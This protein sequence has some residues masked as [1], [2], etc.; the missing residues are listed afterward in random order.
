MSIEPTS[1]AFVAKN[2]L[3]DTVSVQIYKQSFVTLINA[4]SLSRGTQ[5]SEFPWGGEVA[6]L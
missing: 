3:A 2:S 6:L 1:P 5:F 4:L